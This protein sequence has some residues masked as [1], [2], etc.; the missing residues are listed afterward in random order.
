MKKNDPAIIETE[1]MSYSRYKNEF[2]WNQTIDGSY[3][4]KTKTIVVVTKCMTDYMKDN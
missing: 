2:G 1:E 4:S 3:N